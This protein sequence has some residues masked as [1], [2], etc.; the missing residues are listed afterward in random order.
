MRRALS[1]LDLV[2]RRALSTLDLVLRRAL[3][4]TFNDALLIFNDD[5]SVINE[6]RRPS[7]I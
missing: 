2:L 6:G 7:G 1:T 3:S 5:R 4:S